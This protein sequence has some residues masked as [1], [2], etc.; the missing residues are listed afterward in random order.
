MDYGAVVYSV[1]ILTDAGITGW[2][3]GTGSL[4]ESDIQRHVIGKDPFAYEVIWN[5][6][7][8][9]GNFKNVGRPVAWILRCGI[10]WV[11]R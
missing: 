7:N 2:G 10:L 3:Q 8:S 11:R 4:G 9:S 1:E 6:L 5:A